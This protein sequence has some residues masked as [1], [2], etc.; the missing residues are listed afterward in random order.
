MES[1]TLAQAQ[2]AK[3]LCNTEDA[4]LHSDGTNKFGHK[5]SG[6]QVSTSTGDSYT[7][8]LREMC[9]GSAQTTLD[10]LNEI[11]A[12]IEEVANKALGVGNAANRILANIKCTMSDRASTE[13]SFNDLLTA[14][15]SEILPT[16]VD[17]WG[18]LLLEQ[19][20]AMARMYNF[21]CGMHFIVG[22]ADHTAEALRLFEIAHQESETTT[23]STS[24]EPI[25]KQAA[26]CLLELPAKHLRNEGIK[27]PGIPYSFHHS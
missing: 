9:N 19:R 8:G 17:N 13:K 27:N 15:R 1:H 3:A 10:T 5:Y 7:L 12:D 25:L 11:L 18:E 14:Y 6:Y 20:E 22:M 26:L 4:T 16:V 2:L 24:T 23:V 21:F